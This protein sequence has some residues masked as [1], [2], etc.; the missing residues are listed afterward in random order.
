MKTRT[1]KIETKGMTEVREEV[2]TA[3]EQQKEEVKV[4][5]ETV[6]TSE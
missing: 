4:A 3:E 6:A 2:E 5:A 1:V